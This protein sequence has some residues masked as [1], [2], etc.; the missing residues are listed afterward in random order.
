[1]NIILATSNKS[2]LN[3]FKEIFN[4]IKFSEDVN[5]YTMLDLGYD[6]DPDENAKDFRGNAFI[7]ANALLQSLIKDDCKLFD[8]TKDIVVSDDSGLMIDAL[9]GEPGLKSAR[10]LGD[11]TYKERFL[12]ILDRMKDVEGK[13][14]SCRFMTTLCAIREDE[15]NTKVISYYEGIIDGEISTEIRGEDGFGYDPIF[16]LPNIGKTLAE[17]PIKDKNN[18]SHRRMAINKFI[19]DIT[20]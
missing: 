7:K 19:M 10:F 9:N 16:Y 11:K 6:V 5:I 13:D 14:R 1:M 12:Y 3:E 8:H 17:L 15:G 2:K 4:D 20:K 18:I